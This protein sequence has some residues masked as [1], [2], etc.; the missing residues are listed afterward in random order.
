VHKSSIDPSR[1]PLQRDKSWSFVFTT[2]LM[3]PSP[4]T[5]IG[6]SNNVLVACDGCRENGP[7]ICAKPLS[8]RGRNARKSSARERLFVAFIPRDNL[9]DLLCLPR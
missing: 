5:F 4:K 2:G 7:R 9:L 6:W 3:A 1:L 8:T